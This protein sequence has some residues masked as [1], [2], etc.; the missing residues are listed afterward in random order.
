MEQGGA[1]GACCDQAARPSRPTCMTGVCIAKRVSMPAKG[2]AGMGAAASW[3]TV[4]MTAMVPADLISTTN[5]RM[6]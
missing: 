5:R 2:A 3:R 6:V 4:S 1:L